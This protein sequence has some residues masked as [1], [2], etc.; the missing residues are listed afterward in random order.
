MLT[1]L[2]D[3]SDQGMSSCD[4][5]VD[6]LLLISAMET[7]LWLCLEL[8]MCVMSH[9]APDNHTMLI[10]SQCH[11]NVP[12]LAVWSNTDDIASSPWCWCD[13]VLPPGSLCHVITPSL[14]PF[15]HLTPCQC[16]TPAVTGTIGI[17]TEMWDAG[18]V[19]TQIS[20]PPWGHG[21]DGT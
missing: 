21:N 3:L 1:T 5:H 10:M 15:K 6:I 18:G 17:N 4:P 19:F 16:V 9:Q 7:F 14:A 12:Y 2:S 13:H 8:M 20:S 11:C